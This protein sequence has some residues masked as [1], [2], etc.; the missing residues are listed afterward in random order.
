V[1]FL[2]DQFQNFADW[3]S[4]TRRLADFEESLSR[5]SLV[6]LEVQGRPTLNSPS[7][8][9]AVDVDVL[10]PDARQLIDRI[11]LEIHEGERILFRGTSGSGKSTLFRVMAGIWPFFSGRIKRPERSETTFLSQIPYL[12]HGTLRQVILYPT[13]ESPISPEQII[14]MLNQLGLSNLVEK[15]EVKED[16]QKILSPGE[17]QRLA[18]IRAIFQKPKWLFLDEATSALDAS[19]ESHAYEA[20]LSQLP[21]TSIVSIGHRKELEKFHGRVID[22]DVSAQTSHKRRV[23]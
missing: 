11:C 18:L 13:P 9:V 8:V 2:A 10:T 20:I 3:R 22:L 16:W 12:P 23:V 5:A 4:A 14:S 19:N 17:Q 21:N 1:G 6:Q 7:G 15:L